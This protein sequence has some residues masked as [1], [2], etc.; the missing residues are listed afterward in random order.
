M[1][2]GQYIDYMADWTTFNN[3]WAFNYTVSTLNSK[4]IYTAYYSFH[5]NQEQLSCLRGQLAHATVYPYSAQEF[6]MPK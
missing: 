5:T 4:G 1:T 3:V 6:T 2:I